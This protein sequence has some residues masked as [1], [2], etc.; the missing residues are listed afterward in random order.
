MNC[1]NTQFSLDFVILNTL[2]IRWDIERVL[3][4]LWPENLFPTLRWC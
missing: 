1:K 3:G 4:L 2:L